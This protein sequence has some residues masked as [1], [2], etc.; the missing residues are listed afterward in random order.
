MRIVVLIAAVLV[1]ANVCVASTYRFAVS[2]T[3]TLPSGN[4][5]MDPTIDFGQIIQDGNLPGVLDPNSIEVIDKATGQRVPFAR[6]EDFAYGDRGR[7]EWAISDPNHKVYEIGF[8]TVP[9]RPA[10]VPQS[11]TPMVGTGDLL[12]Y[13]G[14][15]PRPIEL[16]YASRLVDITGDG[17]SDLVGAWNY[18]Y[19]PGW[20]SDGLVYHPGV[21]SAPQHEFGDLTRLRYVTSPGSTNYQYFSSLYSTADYADLN[22]DGLVDIVYS[23]SSSSHLSFYLNTG[24]RDEGG[25]PVFLSSGSIP[26]Q[27]STWS[28]CRA[29]DLDQDGAVDLV[30]NN[31]WIRNTNP[32]GWPINPATAVG[33][34]AGLAPCFFDVD[35]DGQLDAVLLQEVAGEGLSNYEIVWR[36]NLT[37]PAGSHLQGYRSSGNY[38]PYMRTTNDPVQS[39]TG[40]DLHARYGEAITIS[41][42]AK[43]GDPNPPDEVG[44]SW[45]VFDGDGDVWYKTLESTGNSP[46]TWTH[47][48]ETIHTDWSDSEANANGWRSHNSNVTWSTLMRDVADWN[49]MGRDLPFTGGGPYTG[50]L[51]NFVMESVE[52]PSTR[53]AEDWDTDPG[54]GLGGWEGDD[55]QWVSDGPPGG[56][57]QF[58]TAQS[59]D[60]I[61]VP[62]PRAVAAVDNGQETG[63]LITDHHYQQVTFFEQTNTP[64]SAPQFAAGAPLESVSAVVGLS[65]QAWPHACDWD[66]DGDL[67]LLVGGGYGLPQI[68]INDGSNGQMALRAPEYILSEGQPIRLTRNAILGGDNWHDMGYPYPDYTDWDDD[69]LPDL[70]I[71]NETNRIFWYKNIGTRANPEFGPQL[72]VIC[73][74]YPDSPEERAETAA[75][76]NNPNTPNA[77]YPYEDDQPFFWRIGAAFADWNGDGLMDFI[78]HDGYTRKATLF[79]QYE[80]GDDLRL[81]KEYAVELTDGRLIDDSIVGRTK[82]WTESFR[83]VDWD[84]DGLTDLIYACAGSTPSNGSIYL[85]RNAGSA[86]APVFEP[87]R[88]LKAFNTPIYVSSHGPHPWAG[89]LD[90][91]GLPDL[92]TCVE[93]SV[94]PFFSHNA[95]EMTSRPSYVTSELWL[96][97]DLNG[98]GFVGGGD[99]DIIRAYWGQHVT[100]GNRFHGDAS[101][102]GFVGG[103][104]LDIIR[105]QWGIALPGAPAVPEPTEFVLLLS[106]GLAAA[107]ANG[108]RRRRS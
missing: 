12:R 72:Q 13:N 82:H 37:A 89:D 93:W 62:F 88:T 48:S 99:L 23:P 2:V 67:D 51:D 44:Y 29:V 105:S 3:S 57:P 28:P 46:T 11:Y 90:G 76:A 56:V 58:G 97:G 60:D 104:D 69:G 5:P 92:L 98:D 108:R 19:R 64:G 79:V 75:L 101:G 95:I 85:L 91:D 18:A 81:R 49:F 87:P 10:L 21:G 71:P 16:I 63:L 31:T 65:D 45:W 30:V 8:S 38:L 47:Y 40:D 107:V 61:D 73:D 52:T 4:V 54:P 103:D 66:G 68:L 83:S 20:P 17:K 55:L 77:P 43:V 42:D 53:H 59:L 78:T 106:V 36:R 25:M 96:A 32:S 35:R 6:T 70:V 80:D 26:R 22:S 27:T 84:G 100:P 102:D 41:L 34:D 7:L 24:E 94:Y 86:N 14:G 74:G 15:E 33:L 50:Y 39:L 9:E 1:S